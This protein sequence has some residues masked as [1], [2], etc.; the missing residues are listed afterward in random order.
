MT[1]AA[2]AAA[3]ISAAAAGG[4]AAAGSASAAAAQK[5]Q[6]DMA[7][8]QYML[9]QSAKKQ[10]FKEQQPYAQFGYG[11]LPL[12]EQQ[13]GA[14]EAGLP[15]YQDRL[16]AYNQAMQDYANRGIS[17]VDT[18]MGQYQGAL[19]QFGQ[20]RGQ[21]QGALDK[22]GRA[23]DQYS[24]AIP[25][26]TRAY[27][28]EQYKQSPLYTPMVNN[29]AE[30]QATPGYQFQLQQ[31][32]QALGQTA[33]ARGGLLSGAQQKASQNYAQQ[34]A[35]TGFQSAWERAQQAYGNAFSQNL[36]RQRQM[37]NVL[38]GGANL[39]GTNVGYYGQGVGQAAT[40][41]GLY[42]QGVDQAMGRAGLYQNAAG[43]AG[44]AANLYGQGLNYQQQ[45]LQ[46]R[47][48]ALRF[49]YGALQDKNAMRQWANNIQGTAAG[50]YGAAGAQG[51][52]AQGD[53][54]GSAIGQIGNIGG[55]LAGYG[56]NQG[57]FGG[58]GGF[59]AGA[60]QAQQNW[61]S[62]PVK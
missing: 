18:A 12:Y 4:T 23:I 48:G 44:T 21:Y 31:G 10:Y 3:G 33:A 41:A 5:Q 19:D 47:L 52:L 32:Q 9:A 24:A 37:G 29:L 16:A 56:V 43:M 13:L 53:I 49:G 30:L 26:M 11:Q 36:E 20:A 35:A 59:G 28:M 62:Q 15:G 2:I 55:G 42:G 6:Q 7:K 40:G 45:A 27:D 60:N 1:G 51:K 22:Y 46:N 38:M 50:N 61:L 17:G 14:Y 57:W 54:L 34:Q 25:E 39:A 58:T 8:M